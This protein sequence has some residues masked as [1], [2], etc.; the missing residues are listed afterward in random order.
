MTNPHTNETW[1]DTAAAVDAGRRGIIEYGLNREPA[2]ALAIQS[3]HPGTPLLVERLDEPE[4]AYYLIPWMTTEGVVFVVQV[5]ASSGAMLGA[6]TFPKPT[7]SPFL[8]PDDALD[9]VGRKFP[10]HTFGTP[11]L[12]WQPC[13]ES[14]SPVR[15]FYQIP[16][17]DKGVFYV[18]M[19]GS[20]FPEPTPLGLGGDACE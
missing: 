19:D 2:V 6:T 5:D 1:I 18:D 7:P 4:N 14:T 9:H 13:R 20:V 12:V 10:Q 3:G 11:R 16:Y 17:S 15:P 8:T